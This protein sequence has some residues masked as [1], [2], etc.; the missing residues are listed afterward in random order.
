MING[1]STH[2]WGWGSEDSDLG[3]RAVAMGLTNPF[4]D[5]YPFRPSKIHR[6]AEMDFDT[7]G[8]EVVRDD[9]QS[10]QKEDVTVKDLT[11]KHVDSMEGLI[12]KRCNKPF[13]SPSLSFLLSFAFSQAKKSKRKSSGVC[14][15]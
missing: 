1:Y 10:E 14:K 3:N 8:S 11:D 7:L 6:M 4:N 2:Y 13:G 9:L 5:F 12:R 15:W